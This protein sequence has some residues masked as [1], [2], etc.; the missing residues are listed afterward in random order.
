LSDGGLPE[1]NVVTLNNNQILLN[2]T[3]DLNSSLSPSAVSFTDT[4]SGSLGSSLTAAF[5]QYNDTSTFTIKDP[6]NYST[7]A[8]FADSSALGTNTATLS[9]ETLISKAV[10]HLML[11]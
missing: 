7:L 1:I 4:T 2:Q 9:S 11:M 8:L 6:N 5:L 10:L 3:N